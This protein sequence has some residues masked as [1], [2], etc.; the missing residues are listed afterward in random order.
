[1]LTN[2]LLPDILQYVFNLY[3]F[4]ETDIPKLE[5]L[6]K[7]KFDIK[8][9]LRVGKIE[10][11][12][13]NTVEKLGKLIIEV[14]FIDLLKSKEEAWYNG[15]TFRNSI[16]KKVYTNI[17]KKGILIEEIDYFYQDKEDTFLHRSIDPNV[18]K[19]KIFYF[20]LNGKLMYIENRIYVVLNGEL[21]HFHDNGKISSRCNYKKNLMDGIQKFYNAKEKLYKTRLYDD[22]VLIDEKII[23]HK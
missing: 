19:L 13:K 16:G 15:T 18:P 17:Y 12:E 6:T 20:G 2:Y 10:R 3:L 23:N 4:W 8:P 1:L 7:F 14:T 11:N 9:H 21:L 5:N 22:G